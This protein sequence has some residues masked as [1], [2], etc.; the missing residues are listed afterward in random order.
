MNPECDRASDRRNFD[1]ALAQPF[2]RTSTLTCR[3][4]SY[5]CIRII[6]CNVFVLYVLLPGLRGSILISCIFR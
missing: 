5:P 6:I 4:T 1:M 3:N 2:N